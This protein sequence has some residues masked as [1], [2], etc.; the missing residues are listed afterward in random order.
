MTMSEEVVALR[1]ENE[2]LKGVIERLF[3]E[4][5]PCRWCKHM[6]EDCSPTDK[7]C[8]PQWGGM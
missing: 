6:K 1:E 3:C 4:F 8:A 5:R 7:S 2:Y